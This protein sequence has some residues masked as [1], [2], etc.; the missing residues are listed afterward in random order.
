[1]KVTAPL[2]FGR[3]SLFVPLACG[4]LTGLL[5][6]SSPAPASSSTTTTT[7]TSTTTTTTPTSTTTT[8]TPTT[9]TTVRAAPAPALAWPATG[10]AAIYV[11]QLSV[12]ATTTNQPREPIASLTKMMTAWVVL[13]RLPLTQGQTGP[14]LTLN[15]SDIDLYNWDL[16]VELSYAEVVK[17]ETLCENTLLRGMLVHSASDY[18]QFLV[19]LTGMHMPT[20][21]SAMNQDARA[22]GLKET[23]YADVTGLSNGNQSTAQ[24]QATLAA[25]LMNDEPIVQGI[26]DLSQVSLPVAGVQVSYTPFAGQG[27][28]VGVKSGYTNAA[29]GCDVMAVDDYIGTSVITTYAVVL[30]EHTYNPLGTAGNDALVLSRSIRASIA[31]VAT[32]S[33]RVI[34]WIGAPSDVKVPFSPDAR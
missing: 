8:T 33:G 15:T 18:A 5:V 13:H 19:T 17:G 4:L 10:S 27:S 20:F 1:M 29:G 12:V 32:A 30:G 7:T 23:R 24:N 2:R 3:R 28:V 11:P 31:N 26:V 22:L 21:V 6:V 14:C 25:T 9:T 34:E 16:A